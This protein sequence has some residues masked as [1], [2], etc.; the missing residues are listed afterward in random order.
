MFIVLRLECSWQSVC[1]VIQVPTV[2]R[3]VASPFVNPVI[4]P[5]TVSD[6]SFNSEGSRTLSELQQGRFIF[7]A[8][9]DASAVDYTKEDMDDDDDGVVDSHAILPKP[10]AATAS[11]HIQIVTSDPM[12]WNSNTL[13]LNR[14]LDD[15]PDLAPVKLSDPMPSIATRMNKSSGGIRDR[16]AAKRDRYDAFGDACSRSVV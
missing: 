16:Y 11:D 3:Q 10:I 2:T 9:D 13:F 14:N 15:R 7:P 12:A 8:P 5:S 4:G 6:P 1:L